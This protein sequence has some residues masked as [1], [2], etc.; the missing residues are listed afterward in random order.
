[1]TTTK[2]IQLYTDKLG[3]L[4]HLKAIK[5][6]YQ[7]GTV[8]LPETGLSGTVKEWISRDQQQI[9]IRNKLDLGIFKQENGFDGEVVWRGDSNDMITNISTEELIKD[10]QLKGI[11]MFYQFATF[12]HAGIQLDSDE[13]EEHYLLYIHYAPLHR[14]I[15]YFINKHTFLL[16]RMFEEGDA[17]IHIDFADYRAV[18]NILYPFYNK[19]SQPDEN[20]T[21]IIQYEEVT[22][23]EAPQADF[24]QMPISQVKD[25]QFVQGNAI[26]NIAF[27]FWGHI[28]F[29]ITLNG[30][31]KWWV[32][33]S[34]AGKTLIDKTF[35]E[36][37]G[38]KVEGHI[39]GKGVAETTTFDL[40][41]FES[42]AIDGLKLEN[43]VIIAAPI[44][45]LF[46]GVIGVEVGGILG[47]DFMSRFV[48]KV[49]FANRQLAFYDAQNFQYTGDGEIIPAEIEANLLHVEM[50]VDQQFT[51]KWSVDTGA[52][53]ASFMYPA[54]QKYQL[55][56]RAG[57]LGVGGGVSGEYFTKV[58]RFQQ[59]EIG[60]LKIDQP[61]LSFPNNP[62]RG[63]FANPKVDGN[64]GTDIMRHFTVYF[65]YVKR[66]LILEKNDQFN[67]PF[68]ENH[69]GLQFR[70][71]D[72]GEIFIKYVAESGSAAKY[73]GIQ[74]GDQLL[75]INE[76]KIAEMSHFYEL[77][78]LIR[79]PAG[80]PISFTI[81][82][83][84]LI[85]QFDYVLEKVM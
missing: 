20:Q 74:K 46:K 68:P 79:Q 58:T 72:D 75:A 69:T 61:L 47:Y 22:I 2:L 11:L 36:E 55:H 16:E 78:N 43:Q 6:Y 9:K 80:N 7:H 32:L 30:V 81:Q 76:L 24:F 54:A 17:H 59:V 29:K 70:G 49:D 19:V 14:K 35:S 31:E 23:D 85:H 4:V 5:H 38:L 84:D 33:D 25:Y 52:G 3:G 8:E 57:L 27:Q 71:N 53:S 40:V 45:R 65:D 66:Q 83:N 73:T 12:E 41:R 50:T 82:R 51:G 26:E 13:N 67:L 64:L 18:G 15:T 39:Q 28:Y 77:Q 62:V 42:L 63:A 10:Y 21:Q 56:Q 44:A 48:T 37:L 60:S 34:G 1:M